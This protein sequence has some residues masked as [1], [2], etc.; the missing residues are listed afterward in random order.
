M[1]KQLSQ[2]KFVLSYFCIFTV[3]GNKLEEKMMT[4]ILR[5]LKLKF[6]LRNEKGLVR[7]YLIALTNCER[8]NLIV[9]FLSSKDS[10]GLYLHL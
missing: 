4:S 3:I 1:V 2:I 10:N 5:C 9:T 7:D 6:D 8:F